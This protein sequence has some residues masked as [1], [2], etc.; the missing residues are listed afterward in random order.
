[1]LSKLTSLVGRTIDRE[2]SFPLEIDGS[3]VVEPTTVTTD[4]CS[5]QVEQLPDPGN[6]T[7]Q[8]KTASS[9][10]DGYVMFQVK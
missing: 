9:I 5:V 2:S 1:M 8:E 6:G 7:E 4:S 3:A 10:D